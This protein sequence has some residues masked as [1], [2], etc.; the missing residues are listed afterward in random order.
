M[1]KYD[2]IEMAIYLV[3]IFASLYVVWKAIFPAL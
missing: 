3:A 2:Y 1:S